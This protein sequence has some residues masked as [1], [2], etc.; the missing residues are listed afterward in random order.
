L[1]AG[2]NEPSGRRDER[3][4]AAA[5]HPEW[6]DVLRDLDRLQTVDIEKDGQR[7]TLRTP[8]TGVSGLLF[9]AAHIALPANL[10]EADA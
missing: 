3:C 4:A 6:G 10:R 5:F 1:I 8:A 9:K 2:R 7:I